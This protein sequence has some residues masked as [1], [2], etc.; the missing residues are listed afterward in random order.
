MDT[1]LKGRSP[2]VQQCFRVP[3]KLQW[4]SITVPGHVASD[5]KSVCDLRLQHQVT[6][7]NMLVEWKTSKSIIPEDQDGEQLLCQTPFVLSD[8][9]W[10]L[11]YCC[12]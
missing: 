9:R 6:A 10:W 5:T 11:V 7:M 1:G 4:L 3:I 8:F 2:F 12:L